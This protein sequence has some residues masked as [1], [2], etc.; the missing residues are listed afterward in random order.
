M[1]EN[2]VIIC[3]SPID[4]DFL[5]Q[6][7][8]II[9]RFFSQNGNR[10]FY[11]ENLNPGLNLNL[12][13]FPKIF[14]RAGKIFLGTNPKGSKQIPNLTII[15]P[16]LLPFRNKLAD[17][18]NRKVFIKLLCLRLKARGLE[19]P[20]IWTYLATPGALELIACLKPEFLVYDCVFDSASHPD[21]PKSAACDERRL[22]ESADLIFTD[23]SLLFKR[24]KEINPETYLEEPGVDFELFSAPGEGPE[25]GIL[26]DINR[27]RICF[28]G[29]IDGMR[30]DLGLIK[31]LAEKKPDWSVILIGPV[32]NTNVSALKL[33]NIFFIGTLAHQGLPSYLKE[34]DV[35]ILPYKIIPFSN[36][37]FPAKIFECL[38]TGK[39]IVSTPLPQ[40]NYFPENTIKIACGK[41]NFITAIEESLRPANPDA[42]NRR[43]A[44]AREN[45]W[46]KR[47]TSIQSIM[48]EALN[49]KRKTG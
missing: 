22:I 31:Y 13:V 2:K 6:R 14:R 29:G 48:E 36:S 26:R 49:N 20:V 23:N 10:V 5:W 16:F 15:T 19:K 35:L 42:S 7:H 24:C 32:I 46:T 38:A 9:M 3:L 1:P 25:P 17:F 11:L 28:F 40:L 27:P 30:L 47:L 8:Q 41:E 4:W 18:I 21:H 43:L 44:I 34:I 12:A 39:P 45:S 33:K 37:I